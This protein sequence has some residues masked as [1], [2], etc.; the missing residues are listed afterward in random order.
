MQNW[1]CDPESGNYT[2]TGW[3]VNAT[4][5]KTGAHTGECREGLPCVQD[6]TSKGQT[7]A[8]D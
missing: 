5:A 7:P 2:Y 1:T 3:L 4:D 8:T 6:M